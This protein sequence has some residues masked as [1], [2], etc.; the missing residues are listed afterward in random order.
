MILV[1][2]P[3]Y[4][5][6]SSRCSLIYKTKWLN[7]SN[8]QY[9]TV[10]MSVSLPLVLICKNS[11]RQND[12]VSRLYRGRHELNTQGLYCNW[13]HVTNHQRSVVILYFRG[14]KDPPQ[15]EGWMPE[16]DETEKNRMI[17]LGFRTRNA[18]N[19]IGIK[20]ESQL[21]TNTQRWQGSWFSYKT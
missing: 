10:I 2:W 16:E 21:R 6:V 15:V 18:G 12:V 5:R 11:P 20:F 17:L 1:L 4:S 7:W 3:L 9:Q 8:W 14:Y 13:E 19:Q